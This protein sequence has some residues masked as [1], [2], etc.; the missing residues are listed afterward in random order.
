[1]ADVSTDDIKKL[2]DITGAGMMDCKKALVENKGDIDKAVD[3]LR[4]KGIAKAAKKADRS[5]GEGRVV[6]YIHGEG[7]IGVLLQLNCETDFVSRTKEFEE[8]GKDIAMHIAAMNPLAIVP[9]DLDKDELKREEEI[10]REQLANE[11]KN[12]EQIEKIVPGKMKK[13][14]SEVC[15]LEQAYVKEPKKTVSEIIKEGISRF[16]EN[17]T[18]ERFNRYQVK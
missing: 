6:S 2:R 16:G 1:M 14:M 3:Y 13:Y 5:T 17:I 15:L 11:G 12:P 8:F 7:T 10:V 4:S 18:V 9:E